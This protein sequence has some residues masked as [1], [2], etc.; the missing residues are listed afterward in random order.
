[1]VDRQGQ[2]TREIHLPGRGR[3]IAAGSGAV[4]AAEPSRDGVRLLRLA[5][6]PVAVTR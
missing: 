1:V 2:L 4:L 3:I 5:L 6:P